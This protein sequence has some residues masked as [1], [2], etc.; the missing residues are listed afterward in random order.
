[1]LL[2]NFTRRRLEF[3]LTQKLKAASAW[4]EEMS[5]LRARVTVRGF[6]QTK[7]LPPWCTLHLH[8]LIQELPGNELVWEQTVSR[9]W[10]GLC[11][12]DGELADDL[13]SLLAETIGGGLEVQA[14][15]PRE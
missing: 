14:V 12:I 2:D 6:Y 11:G 4:N 15:Q 9:R 13:T 5:D 7:T 1:M 10:E 8:L 3:Y